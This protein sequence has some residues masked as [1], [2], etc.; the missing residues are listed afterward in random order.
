VEINWNL[1]LNFLAAILAIVN[2][3]GLIPIWKELTDDA[4]PKVRQKIALL[5]TSAS[6]LI[7]LIFLNAGT[8][9]LDFFKVDL[10]VFKIAGGILLLL[11][12]ISMI[13]GNATHLE[14]RDEK[15]DTDLGLA[16]QRFKKIMVP[17]AVPML[18]GPG[19]ITT[20]FLYGARAENGLDYLVLSIILIVNFAALCFIL[21]FSYK[22]EAKVND[23]FFVAFTRI[24]GIMVAA[25]AVQF[26]VEGLGEIFPA[27]LQGPSPIKDNIE[28]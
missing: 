22:I 13:N 6:V 21:S 27:W 1:S 11:T 23:L 28:D 8:Y 16:K 26:M 15:A 10:A 14:Q 4:I 7:L 12:A 2:P 19:S 18:C 5:A 17:L 3:I 9:L 24:F 20:V 25:I